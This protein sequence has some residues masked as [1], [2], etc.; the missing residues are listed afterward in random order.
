MND[1]SALACDSAFQFLLFNHFS[2]L[3]NVY[4]CVF[5]LSPGALRR[6]AVCCLHY[7]KEWSAGHAWVDTEKRLAGLPHPGSNPVDVRLLEWKDDSVDKCVIAQPQP[8]LLLSV[9]ASS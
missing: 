7:W 8:N 3:F 4:V 2:I 9:C 6:G 1:V 5:S